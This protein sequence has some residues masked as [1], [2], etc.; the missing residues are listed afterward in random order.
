MD[1]ED[2]LKL[3]ILNHEETE[4]LFLNFFSR[5]N[6]ESF[7]RIRESVYSEVT[8]PNER[9]AF[10]RAQTV[11]KLLTATIGVFMSNYGKIMSGNFEGS[12][13]KSLSPSLGNAMKT[14]SKVSVEKIYR[15]PDVIS[16][17]LAGY[18]I[19]GFILDEFITAVLSPTSDYSI[20]LLSLM[21]LQYKNDGA[22]TY[23]KVQSVLDFI[24]GMT[25]LYALKLFSDIKGNA[26]F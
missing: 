26:L 20:K 13:I 12:L 14:V 2:A 7:F 15:H 16:I 21:P 23:S 17:E 10:L 18:N 4:R 9:I 25:D 3:R 11:G 22:N 8:D 24:S 6:D 1:L 19:L 5:E